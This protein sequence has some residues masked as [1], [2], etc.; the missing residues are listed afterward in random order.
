MLHH[1][2]RH[3]VERQFIWNPFKD[4]GPAIRGG[5]IQQPRQAGRV[6]VHINRRHVLARPVIGRLH[7][8]V[9]KLDQ[10]AAI[11]TDRLGN[12]MLR[13]V[14]DSRD[15]VGEADQRRRQLAGKAIRVLPQFVI[16]EQ[17]EGFHRPMPAM[18]SRRRSRLNQTRPV[19][20]SVER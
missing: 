11:G 20:L 17:R 16:G 4:D 7:G 12:A 13:S 15:V 1:T 3:R 6:H 5:P 2:W 8:V 14:D 10:R 9:G 18:G 19:A